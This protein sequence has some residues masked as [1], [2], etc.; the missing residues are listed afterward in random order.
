[1]DSNHRPRSYQDR[2]Q[3][4][5]FQK[6]VKCWHFTS[7]LKRSSIDCAAFHGIPGTNP[8]LRGSKERRN[9]PG[10]RFTRHQRQRHEQLC[11]HRHYVNRS[12][13]L[14]RLAIRSTIRPSSVIAAWLVGLSASPTATAMPIPWARGRFPKARGDGHISGL[15]HALFETHPCV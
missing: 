1:M 7:V 11:L 6:V 13:E 4:A 3:G 15:T 14:V 8:A 9:A 2:S 5:S 10:V 12:P